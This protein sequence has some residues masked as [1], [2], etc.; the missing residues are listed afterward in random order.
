MIHFPF[1]PIY[2]L[3]YVSTVPVKNGRLFPKTAVT[4]VILKKINNKQ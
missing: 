2:G 3:K 1:P 4:S